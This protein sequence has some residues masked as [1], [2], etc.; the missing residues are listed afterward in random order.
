MTIHGLYCWANVTSR[1]G[2][3]I[4]DASKPEAVDVVGEGRSSMKF[5]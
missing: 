4:S 2:E 5:R 1:Y 3:E